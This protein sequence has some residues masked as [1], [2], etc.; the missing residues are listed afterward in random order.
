M[1]IGKIPKSRKPGLTWP[2]TAKHIKEY[3]VF[4]RRHNPED[5]IRKR[6]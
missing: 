6:Y 3:K 2:P 1:F 5:L 4:C